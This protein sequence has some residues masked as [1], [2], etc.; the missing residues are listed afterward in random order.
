MAVIVNKERRGYD[1]V[2]EAGPGVIYY[3][4]PVNKAPGK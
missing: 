2:T 1:V 4:E 3:L